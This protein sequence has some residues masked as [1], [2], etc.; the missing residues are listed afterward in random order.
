MVMRMNHAS[1][2]DGATRI[3][4]RRLN[5]Q[6]FKW[7]FAQNPP[8]PHAVERNPTRQAELF[9]SRLPMDVM[10]H[11]E[12]HLFGNDLNAPGQVHFLLR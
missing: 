5:P 8:I 4:R 11:L 2:A 3:S 12:H 6:V 7:S 9:H 10:G 1:R